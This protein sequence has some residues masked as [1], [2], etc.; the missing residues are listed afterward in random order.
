MIY[1]V[2]Q[3]KQI[4]DLYDLHGPDHVAEWEPVDVHDLAHVSWARHISA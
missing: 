3:R 1:D 4:F 2:L